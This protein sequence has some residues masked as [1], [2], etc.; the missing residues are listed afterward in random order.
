LFPQTG[1]NT[2][3]RH[4][5]YETPVNQ[6]REVVTMASVYQKREVVMTTPVYLKR[7]VVMTT[8]VY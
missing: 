4:T 2:A 5:K 7:E 3:T 6:K 8:P 1:A